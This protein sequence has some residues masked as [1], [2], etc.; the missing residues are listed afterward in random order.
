M[1]TYEHEGFQAPTEVAASAVATPSE[2]L[3]LLGVKVRPDTKKRL[4][5]LASVA[6]E[7]VSAFARKTLELATSEGEWIQSVVRSAILEAI[8]IAIAI[9]P[10]ENP[11]K[12][13]ANE[14][15]E[16][17]RE[18]LSSGRFKQAVV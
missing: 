9:V 16:Q 13:D 18:M 3:V 12:S 4:E 17:Y 10:E 15:L 7:P 5:E 8:S 6:G 14:V 11:E 1:L 2:K